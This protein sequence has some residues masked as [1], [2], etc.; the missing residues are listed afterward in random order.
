VIQVIELRETS[1]PAII[2][3][4]YPLG[5]IDDA[6]IA[7]KERYISAFGQILDGLSYLHA[8]GVAHRDL[9]PTNFLIEMKPLFKV[10]ITDFGFAK[11]VTDTALLHSFCGSPRYT[12]PEVF[13]GR[14]PG[15][16]PPVDVWSLGVIVFG[17]IYRT[18]DPPDT[19]EPKEGNMAELEEKWCDWIE[20]WANLLL[21]KLEDQEQDQLV[22]LLLRM[23]EFKVKDRWPAS[24]CLA[25]GFEGSLFK[26]RV[27]DGLIVYASDPDH[28]DLPTEEGDDGKK[29]PTAASPPGTELSRSTV[30]MSSASSKSKEPTMLLKNI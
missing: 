22:P 3:T 13:P 23:I 12:A 14:S 11:V 16:G 25:Q 6:G 8:K 7:D 18:P 24:Q 10:V 19:P 30:P 21:D 2:M 20:I 1:E 29:T 17:W 26:R 9:K 28:F 5:N 27:A 4:Y 15:H